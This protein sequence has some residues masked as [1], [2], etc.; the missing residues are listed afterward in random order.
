MIQLL[1]SEHPD[2]EALAREVVLELK[3]R[4]LDDDYYVACMYD[5]NAKHVFTFG[6]YTTPNQAKKA[7]SSLSSA[8]PQ[9]SQGW[10]SKLKEV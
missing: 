5:P 2:V 8:G 7:L 10:V 9:P 3:Q 6:P 1:E 4:W